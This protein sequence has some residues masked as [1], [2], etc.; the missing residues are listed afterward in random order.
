MKTIF[1][2]DDNYTN[3][4]AA[5]NALEGTYR[6]FA[7]S[8]SEKMFKLA[9]KIIPDLILLD[10]DM[11]EM[12]G[13]ET[14]EVLKTDKNL[15]DVPVVFLTS[16]NDQESEL[17]GF[18]MGALDFI[19]KPFSA[20]VLIRRIKTHIEQDKLIKESQQ[21]LRNIHHATISIISD[22]VERRDKV[23]GDHIER[24][25]TFLKLIIDELMRLGYYVD[26][27]S[28]WDLELLLPSAQLH[29]VGKISISDTLLNKPETLT[30][31]EFDLIKHH[32]AVGEAI[33]DNI[34]NKTSDDIFL[35][36]AK[37]FAS[38][39]HEKWNGSGYPRGLCEENIPL[40]GRIMAVVDVYDALISERPYKKA[41]EHS[42]AVEIIKKDSGTH[43]D[44]RVVDAFLNINE[45]L[46]EEA[47]RIN[48]S[49]KH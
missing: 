37:K 19:N 48:Q 35:N 25:Q 45:A 21:S 33:I 4:T 5:K 38:Y 36:H 47:T 40:E 34:I 24:T 9:K 14:M 43:F 46:W 20:P 11:P 44:P 41:F 10:I 2:V 32:C 39:H 27:L 49:K 3:L 30:D 12:D 31:E 7:M 1:I 18:D 8:S 26:E 28:T 17:R 16:L 29:D 22:M 6:S 13:F 42:K 15:K 23:T